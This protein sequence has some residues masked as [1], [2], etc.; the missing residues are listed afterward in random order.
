MEEKHDKPRQHI[1]KQRHHFVDKGTSTQ[2]YGFSR[3]RVRMWEL[4]HKE[5][6]MPNWC[7]LIVMLEKTLESRLEINRDQTSQS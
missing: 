1:N 7:F 4:D 5:G 2:S 3:S 6:E